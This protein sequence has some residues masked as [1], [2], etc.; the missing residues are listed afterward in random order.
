VRRLARAVLTATAATALILSAITVIAAR[1]AAATQGTV[2][3]G[4]CPL[5]SLGVDVV[6]GGPVNNSL[7]AH[8]ATFSGSGSLCVVERSTTP[9]V[10]VPVSFTGQLYSSAG[11]SCGL[12]A[13]TGTGTLS[14]SDPSW[15]NPN[16]NLTVVAIGHVVV[17]EIVAA[18]SPLLFI[19]GGV[20]TQ[21][22]LCETTPA[23]HLTWLGPLAF[24]DPTV[25]L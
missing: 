9:L 12:A 7:G 20:F 3:A 6:S 11:W 1:P 21:T 17:F 8:T 23:T 2:W 18:A 10:S 4:A 16:L 14:I 24:E 15:P 19:G 5:M 25:E 13:M 22:T